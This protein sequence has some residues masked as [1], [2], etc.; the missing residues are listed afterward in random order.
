MVGGEGVGLRAWP[1]ADP[2]CRL[3]GQDLGSDAAVF[4]S[5]AALMTGGAV[6]VLAESG[7]AFAATGADPL[8]Y[9]SGVSGAA[10]Y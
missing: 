1:A 2:A 10:K 4:C 9:C 5:E 7:D 6:V 8:H 3:F